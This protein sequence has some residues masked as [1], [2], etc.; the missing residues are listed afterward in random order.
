VDSEFII[1]LVP[2]DHPEVVIAL[3]KDGAVSLVPRT[4]ALSPALGMPT[5][6][7]I[8]AAS[9]GPAPTLGG[10]ALPQPMIG[11]TSL[12]TTV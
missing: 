11:H 3:H 10:Q 8:V 12:P 2:G 6:M 5:P 1:E 4:P 7:A 9:P